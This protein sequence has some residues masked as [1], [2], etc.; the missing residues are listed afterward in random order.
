MVDFKISQC[1]FY[2]FWPSHFFFFVIL[3][4]LFPLSFSCFFS[5]SLLLFM[6]FYLLLSTFFICVCLIFWFSSMSVVFS[7][8]SFGVYSHCLLSSIY[9]VF[10]MYFISSFRQLNSTCLVKLSLLFLCW[11]FLLL[12]SGFFVYL[13]ITLDSLFGLYNPEFHPS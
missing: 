2:P 13:S 4:F 10:F 9:S 5:G 8:L 1:I 6:L 12:L 11:C 3:S 7:L